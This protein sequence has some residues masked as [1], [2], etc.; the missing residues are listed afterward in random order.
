VSENQGNARKESIAEAIAQ[1]LAGDVNAY[2]II[3]KSCDEPLRSF[4]T[5]RYGSRG[6]DFVDEVLSRTHIYAFAHLGA[7]DAGR[8]ASFQTWLNWQSRSM[9]D[10][11]VRSESCA[12]RPV[13]LDVERYADSIP[14]GPGL[15]EN[16]R[17]HESRRALW[18]EYEALGADERLS[19]AKHDIEG[20]TFAATATAMGV[21]VKRLRRLRDAA[22]H[23]WRKRLRRRGLDQHSFAPP[24][25]PVWTGQSRT[26]VEDDWTMSATAIPPEGSEVQSAPTEEVT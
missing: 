21:S 5:S 18:Q 12:S 16:R 7:Y 17:V 15:E 2:E 4:V 10:R 3:Y 19:I 23:R 8:G 14:A 9:A 11:Q 20:R 22:L 24:W 6:R 26:D 13:T 1:V 25:V